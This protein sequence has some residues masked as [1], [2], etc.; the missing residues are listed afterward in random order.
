MLPLLILARNAVIVI[1]CAF[2]VSIMV[3]LYGFQPGGRG[4]FTLTGKVAEGVPLPAV[5]KFSI[6]ALDHEHNTT[7]TR[8]TS[9]IFSVSR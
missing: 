6:D 4:F 5:P 1:L 3:D 2:I 7:I 9:E 8:T